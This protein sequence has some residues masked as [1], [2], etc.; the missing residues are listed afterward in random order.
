MFRRSA[1][2]L[3]NEADAETRKG[4]HFKAAELLAKANEA[5]ADYSGARSMANYEVCDP[6]GYEDEGVDND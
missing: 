5:W 6:P 1:I 4:N 2:A 3:E